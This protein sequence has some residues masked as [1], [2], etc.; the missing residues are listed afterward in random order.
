MVQN[1]LKN[2]ICTV[3]KWGFALAAIV[4]AVRALIGNQPVHR[5]HT[6]EDSC[7]MGLQDGRQRSIL[8]NHAV[9]L[10]P[11]RRVELTKAYSDVVQAYSNGQ[12]EVLHEWRLKL[13]RKVESL[14]TSDLLKIDRPF[15]NVVYGELLTKMNRILAKEPL[16]EDYADAT[17][18]ERHAASLLELV[19]LYG[20]IQIQRRKFENL[21]GDLEALVFYRLTA[22][23]N[24]YRNVGR[25]DLERAAKRFSSEWIDQIESRD[26]YTRR[27]LVYHIEN[28]R[29][30]GDNLMD[31]CKQSWDEI[32]QNVVSQ[33]VYTLKWAG[34][35]PKW[36]V[37]FKNIPRNSSEN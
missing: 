15:F 1:S 20:D 11:D 7:L 33:T 25:R 6:V 8:E 23:E 31:Q 5:C 29:K 16:D 34:Y 36:L 22:Y 13:P 18:F 2:H 28:C 37:D 4:L 10:E 9:P 24:Y 30:W 26:G 19:R 17:A 3:C 21:F 35:T 27:L 14:A 12:A 32:S